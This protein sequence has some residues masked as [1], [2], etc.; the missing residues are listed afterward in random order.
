MIKFT[1]VTKEFKG[2]VVLDKISMDIRD[3]ELTVLIGPSGCGKTTT[4]KM[5][6]RL[7]PTSGG[8]IYIDDVPIESI[9]KVELRRRMGYVIQQGG[10]FPHMTIRQNIEIIEE[11]EKR[12]KD[13]VLENTLKLMKMVDMMKLNYEVDEEGKEPSDVAKEFL[14]SKGLI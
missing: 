6:N 14:Q 10:L 5:I 3:G 12:P 1:E 11:L 13:Q 8:E 9:D 7:L 2:H 4:L